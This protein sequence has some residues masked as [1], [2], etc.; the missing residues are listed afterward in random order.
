M[1]FRGPTHSISSPARSMALGVLLNTIKDRLL[2]FQ[3]DFVKQ[4][5]LWHFYW[6]LD[7][8]LYTK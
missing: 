6:Y 1:K 2:G 8:L 5:Y 4:L 3:A 7:I